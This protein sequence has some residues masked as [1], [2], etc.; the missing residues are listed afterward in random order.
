MKVF[1]RVSL[2]EYWHMPK[3]Y[4]VIVVLAC[5]QFKIN[6]VS[7]NTIDNR[8]QMQ[9]HVKDTVGQKKNIFLSC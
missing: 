2:E 3:K 9:S 7:A 6:V 8:E 5:T 1:F 4:Q